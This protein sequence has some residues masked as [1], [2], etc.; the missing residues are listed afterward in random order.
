MTD[1]LT[2]LDR[3][4]RLFGLSLAQSLAI[5]GVIHVTVGLSA[6][7]VAV[8][9]GKDWKWWIPIGLIVGTP[10]LIAAVKLDPEST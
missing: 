10:A 8:Q 6:A 2:Q 7:I 1:F 9:K 4:P 3:L 5:A